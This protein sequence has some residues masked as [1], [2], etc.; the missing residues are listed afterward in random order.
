MKFINS[1]SSE[2]NTDVCEFNNSK[3]CVYEPPCC[4]T[5]PHSQIDNSD[6]T[7]EDLSPNWGIKQEMLKI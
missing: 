4:E 3:N 2:E 6:K 7:R 5:L 1:L